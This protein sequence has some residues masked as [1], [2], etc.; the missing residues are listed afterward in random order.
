MSNFDVPPEFVDNNNGRYKTP[1]LAKPYRF[2]RATRLFRHPINI[3]YI[4]K[5]L[6]QQNLTQIISNAAVP[7]FMDQLEVL[8]TLSRLN[9]NIMCLIMEKVTT[10]TS[11]TYGINDDSFAS[12]FYNPLDL[13]TNNPMNK[14]VAWTPIT[15]NLRTRRKHEY[16][17][18]SYGGGD[19]SNLKQ[20]IPTE[21]ILSQYILHQ[22]QPL[23]YG[24]ARYRSNGVECPR[25]RPGGQSALSRG[26]FAGRQYDSI[27]EGLEQGGQGD[28][29]VQSPRKLHDMS[30]LINKHELHPETTLDEVIYPD[31]VRYLA[32]NYTLPLP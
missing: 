18:A 30:P 14:K 19:R 5:E 21:N 15:I 31:D 10:K 29:G 12:G 27:D 32:P 20:V 4:E 28:F 13:L 9:Q 17:K 6:R 16:T 23:M 2:Y 7:Q 8:P 3:G 11:D 25:E 1:V 26:Y 22:K 24:A